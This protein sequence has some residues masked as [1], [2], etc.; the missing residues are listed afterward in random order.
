[1]SCVLCCINENNFIVSIWNFF[2]TSRKTQKKPE[3]K[4]EI[5]YNNLTIKLYDVDW[6]SSKIYQNIEAFDASGRRV[7]VVEKPNHSFHFWDMQIDE[8][9]M[10]LDVDGGNSYHY[11]INL[12][13]GEII[14]AFIIK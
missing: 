3:V 1:M 8:E 6:Y 5:K 10:Q 9:K 7:W 2:S 13:T 11:V 12:E 4:K 14:N